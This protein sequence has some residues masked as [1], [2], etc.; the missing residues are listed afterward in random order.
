MDVWGNCFRPIHLNTFVDPVSGL[1]F[2]VVNVI[3]CKRILLTFRKL[4]FSLQYLIVEL[5]GE[6]NGTSE[7]QYSYNVLVF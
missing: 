2:Q 3:F 6:S 5:S 1:A 4:Y 7:Y